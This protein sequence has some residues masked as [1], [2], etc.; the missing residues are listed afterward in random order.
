MAIWAS[1]KQIILFMCTFI[2]GNILFFQSFSLACAV[3]TNLI[4]Y[5][6]AWTFLNIFQT[7][8]FKSANKRKRDYGSS[9]GGGADY[10]P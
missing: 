8:P 10:V 9:I 3:Y 7:P 5:I 6:A 2:Y 4:L 1:S